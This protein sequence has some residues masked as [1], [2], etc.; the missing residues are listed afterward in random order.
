MGVSGS[1]KT[2]IATKLAEVSG[3]AFAEGDDFHPP[4]NVAKMARGEPLSDE[5]RAPWLAALAAWIRAQDAAGRSTV[6]ACSALKRAYR[7]TLRA[8][9]PGR[10]FFL[11]LTAPR[12]ALADRLRRRRGH[13]MPA[14]LLDSQL[15]TLEPL[16]PDEPGVALDATQPPEA[17]VARALEQLSA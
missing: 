16:A 11:H 14:S 12:A 5:D 3:C 10:V 2:T 9:A 6:L 17:V 7:D 15:A 13:Y 8:G 1:G 4:G